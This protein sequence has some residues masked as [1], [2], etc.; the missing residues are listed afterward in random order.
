MRY[1]LQGL[2]NKFNVSIQIYLTKS[3]IIYRPKK[4]KIYTQKRTNKFRQFSKAYHQYSQMKTRGLEI[5]MI[6]TDCL[7]SE[8]PKNQL[9]LKVMNISSNIF[10]PNSQRL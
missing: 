4:H 3:A 6:R 5:L 7:D 1:L 8:K 9:E 10:R 2:I